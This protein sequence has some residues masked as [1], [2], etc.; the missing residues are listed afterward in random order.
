[1]TIL[2]KLLLVRRLSKIARTADTVGQVNDII[3]QDT[4]RDLTLQNGFHDASCNGGR[5]RNGYAAK[6]NVDNGLCVS[7]SFRYPIEK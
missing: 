2:W 3:G 5:I 1:M 4:Q 7:T 6:T